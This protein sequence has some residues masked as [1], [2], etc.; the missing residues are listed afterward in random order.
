VLLRE[1]EPEVPYPITREV[2][3]PTTALTFQRSRAINPFMKQARSSERPDSFPNSQ[4]AISYQIIRSAWSRGLVLA[5][6]PPR[7]T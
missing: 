5:V 2:L 4:K 6:T 1:K 7:V 3:I